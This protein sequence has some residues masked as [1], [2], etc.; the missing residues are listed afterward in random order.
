MK[1]FEGPGEGAEK[2]LL[3]I[4]GARRLKKK[5]IV[6]TISNVKR[7]EYRII[8]AAGLGITADVDK[9]LCKPTVD[10]HELRLLVE[11]FDKRGRDALFIAKKFSLRT[12]F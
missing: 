9:L 10:K 1:G 8:P 12:N 4:V 5:F 7:G 6:S 3:A 2:F 11:E